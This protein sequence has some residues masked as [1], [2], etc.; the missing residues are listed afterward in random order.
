MLLFTKGVILR[1]ANE[2]GKYH[3]K[4]TAPLNLVP[5]FRVTHKRGFLNE[6]SPLAVCVYVSI[7]HALVVVV[8][9]YQHSSPES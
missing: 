8:Y 5:S 9:Y 1:R 2:K 7:E 4:Q 6:H 3:V